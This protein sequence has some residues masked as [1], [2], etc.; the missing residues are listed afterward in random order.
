M[1]EHMERTEVLTDVSGAYD[2]LTQDELGNLG[3]V[4]GAYRSLRGERRSHLAYVS[5]PITSGKRYYE[6]L[7]EHGA[8]DAKELAAKAGGDALYRLVIKPNIDQGIAF[9]DHLGVSRKDLLF[10]A[11][12]VF[13]A[14]RWRWSQDAYMSLWYRVLGELAGAHYLMDGWEYSTGGVKEVMFTVLMQNMALWDEQM[15]E[16]GMENFLA[17]LPAERRFSEAEAMSRVRI[18][19]ADG[20]GIDLIEAINKIALAIQDLR[21]RGFPHLELVEP[22]KRMYEAAM[23]ADV[24]CPLGWYTRLNDAMNRLRTASN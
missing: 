20:T 4:L 10:I 12:S 16:Y 19:E 6:V 5:M 8:K 21:G 3:V 15:K 22:A 11:P 23:R 14:K 9:A 18:Y 13:E 2:R 1:E 24:R 7:T 17:D